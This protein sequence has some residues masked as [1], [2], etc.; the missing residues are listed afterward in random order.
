MSMV[1]ER[2]AP[3]RRA[4]AVPDGFDPVPSVGRIRAVEITV[5]DDVPGEADAVAFPVDARQA[6]AR[7]HLAPT[8]PASRSVGFD[9]SAGQTHLIAGDG[10]VRVAVGVGDVASL[11]AAALRDAAAAFGRATYRHAPGPPPE[12]PAL[13]VEPRVPPRRG[14]GYRRGGPARALRARPATRRWG[15]GTRVTLAPAVVGRRTARRSPGGADRGRVLAAV[16]RS[17]ATSPTPRRRTSPRPRFGEVAARARRGARA[18]GRG[19]RPGRRSS[20][21]GC[22]G[23]ARRQRAAAR[24]AA[25]LIKLTYTPR[26]ASR[27]GTSR[28]SARASCTTRAASASSRATRSTPR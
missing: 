27:P 2:Q 18:R 14:P 24:R 12:L 26:P 11:D 15:S 4:V 5:V 7:R 28:S 20:S 22:G 16:Q 19:L 3:Q 23:H 21:M 6:R 17:P 10:S 8:R 25:A 13:G 1:A 9:G